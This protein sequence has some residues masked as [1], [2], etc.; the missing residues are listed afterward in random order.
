MGNIITIGSWL[1]SNSATMIGIT[2][3]V[4]FEAISLFEKNNKMLGEQNN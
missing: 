2:N 3:V 4:F 1:E